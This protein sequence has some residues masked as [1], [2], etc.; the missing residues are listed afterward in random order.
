MLICWLFEV[1]GSH[2]EFPFHKQRRSCMPDK[3]GAS[4]LHNALIPSQLHQSQVLENDA[5]GV[6]LDE[7]V[8]AL[9]VENDNV[10]RGSMKENV[11]V[12]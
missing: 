6:A 11:G 9:A 12:T 8:I 4:H 3:R 10:L 2:L 5:A 1:H 7:G